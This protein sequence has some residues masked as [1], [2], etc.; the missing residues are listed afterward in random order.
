M[1]RVLP[2]GRLPFL[3]GGGEVHGESPEVRA[4]REAREALA[5]AAAMGRITPLPEDVSEDIPVETGLDV[6]AP[7]APAPAAPASTAQRAS[8]SAKT[9]TRGGGAPSAPLPPTRARLLDVVAA[10]SPRVAEYMRKALGLEE[11]QQEAA[12]R[13][14]AV[15]LG[16]A[17]AMVNEAITG[18]K[19]DRGAYD[20]L[21]E[22]AQRPVMD[23]LA[24]EALGR[25]E[26]QD[27]GGERER[28]SRLQG[29]EDERANAATRQ[30][31]ELARDARSQ[32]QR[33]EDATR[34]D[35]RFNLERQDA[36]AARSQQQ[37]QFSARM[38]Q[39]E[40]LAAAKAAAGP[41][42]LGAAGLPPEERLAKATTAAKVSPIVASLQ[43][44]EQI[45]P[46]STTGGASASGADAWSRAIVNAPGGFGSWL[47]TDKGI[48]LTREVQNLRDVVKR[49][50]SGAA[51]TDAEEASY[52]RL[53]DDAALSDPRALAVGL[54]IV[55]REVQQRLVDLNAGY[56]PAVVQRYQERGG[57]T[58]QSP[59]IA[60]TSA[61]TPTPTGRRAT[62]PDGSVWE[63]L[64]D[65]TS[66][67][68]R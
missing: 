22:E 21:G 4:R 46:G 29:A 19:Y 1:A 5:R 68:V 58:A 44:I 42:G 60:G 37:S 64:S 53:I 36:A 13:A 11:P 31:T 41:R 49:A 59:I 65:G 47:S 8:V 48:A 32:E 63:E 55:R 10:E 18:A 38:A 6:P 30:A 27:Y 9:S 33:V 43:R 52:L 3:L 57:T 23:T 39:D 25:Q 40:R 67:Q 17:G 7:P 15:N 28:V 24:R 56:D 16:R 45:L 12:R 54:D 51:I 14:L 50:R 35:A 26:W 66:R 20:A 34:A 61:P 62:M 2:T